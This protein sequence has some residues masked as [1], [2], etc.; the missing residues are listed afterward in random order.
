[1]ILNLGCGEKVITDQ[2][3]VNVDVRVLRGVDVVHDLNVYPWP[4]ADGLF[5]RVH[6]ED[7]LEHLDSVVMAMDEIWRVLQPGGVVWIRGPDFRGVNAC[8]DPTHRRA[9][10]EYSFDYL[11]P[12]LPIG[13]KLMYLTGRKFRVMRAEGD[14]EDLVF[15][16][17][18]MMFEEWREPERDFADE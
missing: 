15:L 18:K 9:F 10:N 3:A 5:D 11:D 7:V 6:A 16:L 8:A 17:C 14:G 1:M 13:D 4:F 2:P 12:L